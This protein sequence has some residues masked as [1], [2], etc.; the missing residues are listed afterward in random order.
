MAANISSSNIS[1]GLT[2]TLNFRGQLTKT[3][4]SASTLTLSLTSSL[5]NEF[6]GSVTG[7]IINLGIAT[8]YGI[9]HE[10]WIY[11]ESTTFISVRNNGGTELLSLAP[12]YRV[13][14]IL[15]DNSTTSGVWILGIISAASPGGTLTAMFASTANSVSNKFLDTENIAASNTLPAVSARTSVIN[16]VTYS[17]SNNVSSG[18]IELY[19]NGT[20]SVSTAFTTTVQTFTATLNQPVAAGDKLSCK[21]ASGASG[22][23]KPLVKYYTT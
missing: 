15:E 13:R 10:W 1:E 8:N 19:I 18:T 21:I 5:N 2:D 17:N 3:T 9:G 6:I 16:L 4:C 12:S 14:V 20:L 23:A 7:Q 11:N 22:V